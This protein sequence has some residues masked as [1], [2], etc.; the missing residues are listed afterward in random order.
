MLFRSWRA[1]FKLKPGARIS[2]DLLIRG[3]AWKLQEEMFG[4]LGKVAARRLAQLTAEL[5]GHGSIKPGQINSYKAGTRL[6]REWQ[7]RVHEVVMTE[8]GFIWSGNTYASLS[9]IAR[10][11]TGT[12]WSGPR[13]FGLK[14]AEGRGTGS[15]SA[16]TPIGPRAPSGDSPVGLGS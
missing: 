8:G 6:V 9:Q 4:G 16:A 14:G 11:I 5:D 1:V 13:F 12:R 15:R 7:G 10:L 3:L 2:R